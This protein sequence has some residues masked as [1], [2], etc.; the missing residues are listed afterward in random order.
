MLLSVLVTLFASV[1]IIYNVC[2]C[3][4]VRACVYIYICVCVCE[5]EREREICCVCAYV[6]IKIANVSH[7]LE[8]V[9]QLRCSGLD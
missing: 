3:V 1:C 2:V 9:P 8:T 6:M 4:C 5:R 7:K